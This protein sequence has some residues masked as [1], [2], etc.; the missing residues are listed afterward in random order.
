MLRASDL[1]VSVHTLPL[2]RFQKVRSSL[3]QFSSSRWHR[4][5]TSPFA[6]FR[7]FQLSTI[8]ISWP[9]FMILSRISL[10]RIF[11]R[12]LVLMRLGA[13]LSHPYLLSLPEDP[14]PCAVHPATP[15]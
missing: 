5:Q 12:T 8:E 10:A 1:P 6:S 14:I 3:Y 4:F 13:Y 11:A 9:E 15:C 2:C 7:V